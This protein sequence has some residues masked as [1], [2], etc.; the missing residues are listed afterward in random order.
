MSGSEIPFKQTSEHSKKNKRDLTG[1]LQPLTWFDSL[2]W[3][4]FVCLWLPRPHYTGC[5]LTL[6]PLDHRWVLAFRNNWLPNMTRTTLYA[7]E[8]GSSCVRQPTDW[9]LEL[10]SKYRPRNSSAPGVRDLCLAVRSGGDGQSIQGSMQ[11]ITHPKNVNRV[12]SKMY[13]WR[14]C[15]FQDIKFI[16][17]FSCFSFRDRMFCQWSVVFIILDTSTEWPNTWRSDYS[18]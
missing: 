16:Q 3:H 12:Q 17:V 11:R 7:V 5:T 14:Y 2:L 9:V 1:G 13:L 6:W 8:T 18:S 4:D 15:T 10:H